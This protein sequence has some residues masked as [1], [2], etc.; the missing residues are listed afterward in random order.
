MDSRLIGKWHERSIDETV[1]IFDACPPRIKIS[2]LESGYYFCDP[3]CVYEQ[4]GYLC[5]EINDAD[6]RRVYRIRY[7][8]GKLKGC[9]TQYGET[10]PLLLERIADVPEDKPYC[11]LP[12][13]AIIPKSEKT[14]LELLQVFS[15]YDRDKEC[16]YTDTFVLDGEVPQVLEQ[17]NYSEILK[18]LDRTKD[19]IVFGL[20]DFVCDHFQHDG[21]HS[22]G[23]DCSI[24]AL[25]L[26]C[27]KNN[28]KMNCRGLAILLASLLRMNGIKA[29]HITCMPYEDPFDDCH[30]VVDCLLPSGSRIML[31]PTFRAYLKDQYGAYVSLAHLRR[32]LTQ[33]EPI[34]EN[35]SAGYNGTGFP[36]EYYREYKKKNTFRFSRCTLSKNGV[37]GWKEGF[38]YIELI[39]KGFPAERFSES[40]RSGFVNNDIAFWK[41]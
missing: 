1:D 30:V 33:G 40:K 24:E 13:D 8:E 23:T 5:Y 4:D 15:E 19:E 21:R 22:F 38:P 7:C 3:N 6:N 25:I 2:F 11:F 10:T 12:P 14:R 20:L 34:F 35:A 31:D 27:E 41:M 18:G 17:Y 26:F 37:D 39:P 32:M 16:S 36:R 29:R 9:F 28:G